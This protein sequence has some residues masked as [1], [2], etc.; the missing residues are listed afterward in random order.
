MTQPY[1]LVQMPVTVASP[2]VMVLFAPFSTAQKSCPESRSLQEQAL[3]WKGDLSFIDSIYKKKAVGYKMK[4]LIRFLTWVACLITMIGWTWESPCSNQGTLTLIL[5]REG[6]LSDWVD[7]LP[8]QDLLSA[9][10]QHKAW[11]NRRSAV[12]YARPIRIKVLML[13]SISRVRI[14]PSSAIISHLME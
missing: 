3:V 4:Q 9:V 11:S 12:L 6:S 7:L 2:I 14:L 5:K 13:I 10:S 8:Q 1:S